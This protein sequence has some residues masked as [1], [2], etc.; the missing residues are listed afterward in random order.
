MKSPCST[1]PGMSLKR[2]AAREDRDISKVAI[3]IDGSSV[4]NA[5]PS[6]RVRCLQL[7][8]SAVIFLS[9]TVRA[10]GMNLYWQ[11]D[12]EYGN[13]LVESATTTSSLTPSR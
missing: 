10:N 13:K 6:A 2:R 12:C 8:S 9:R 4:T 3:Q 7:A 11:R 5:V 1:T